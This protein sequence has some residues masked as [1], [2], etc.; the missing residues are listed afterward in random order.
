MRHATADSHRPVVAGALHLVRAALSLL[1]PARFRIPG[2]VL[3]LF[4]ATS[5]ATRL[6]L[7]AFNAD[8]GVLLP[9][10]LLGWLALGTLFDLGVGVFVALPFAAAAWLLPDTARGRWV[11]APLVLGLAL[12]ACAAFT[13]VAAAEL[14]FW[15]E[16][17]VRFNFIAVDYLV[18]TS[19]VAG[20]IRE[21]YP[22]PLL[23]GGAALATLA[24]FASLARALWRATAPAGLSFGR[25][26][27]VFAGLALLPVA[28]FLGLDARYKDFTAHAPSAQLAGNGWFEFL[29]AFRHNEIDYAQFYRTVPLAEAFRVL[30]G[31][32]EEGAPDQRFVAEA[33]LPIERDVT[34]RGPEK[35]LNVVLVTVESLSAEF[36][37]AFGNTRGLTPRLDALA[38]EGLVFTR[39]YATGTRT[40]R[41]LEAITLSF[42]PTPGHSVIKRPDNDSLYTLGEIFADKG[43]T[44]VFLYGGY[45]YFDNMREFF[46]GNGYAV[47]DRSALAR[48]E[49]HYANIWGVADE[50][51][52]TLTLRELDRRAATG[53]PFF[54][55]VMTTSNHRPYSYP[56]GRIAIP[57]GSGRDGAVRY[58]D[59]AIGDFLD[60]A[61]THP[62][63]DDT[64]FVFVADHGASARGTTDLPVDRF[65]I[66]LIVWAPKHLR[67]GRVDHLASQIDVGPTL[68]GLLGFSY[69]SRFFGQDIMTEGA[70]HQRAL[71]ANYQTVGYLEDGVLVELRPRRRYRFVD[72]ATGRELPETAHNRHLLE[73]AVSYYEGA[74]MAFRSGALR[75]HAQ[76][77]PLLAR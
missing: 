63:F 32:F 34:G 42:P 45:A 37:G 66:P 23:A 28:A 39:L 76:Q 24:L 46:G 58:T 26:S 54:A 68:L 35:R 49:I 65:H 55:H 27:A 75:A 25:R 36:L 72:A 4:L 40:V 64:V 62:W 43:Y 41:G 67:P 20:N 52:F 13:L 8:P 44:A 47:V 74:S 33:R 56:A 16:F 73:E 12:A 29:H 57:S 17:G 19:E 77:A 53:T 71:L 11:L 69:R 30:R 3:L 48:D 14:V 10:R 1:F 5:L 61:R 51:L 7:A 22:V 2:I 31:E 38:R 9:Q 15:N 6:G 21:S 18:Y 70:G 50:D 59:W 60:R